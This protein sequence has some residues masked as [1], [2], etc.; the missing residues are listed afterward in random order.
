MRCAWRW[1]GALGTA[2]RPQTT[3]ERATIFTDAQA[4]KTGHLHK[5]PLVRPMRLTRSLAIVRRE[6]TEEKWAEARSWVEGR[7][8]A[9]NTEDAAPEQSGDRMLEAAGRASGISS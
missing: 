4:S 1:P 7:I 6:I 2:A 3:P 5:D 8:D 9:E